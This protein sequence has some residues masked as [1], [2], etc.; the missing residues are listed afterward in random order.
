MHRCCDRTGREQRSQKARSHKVL[1]DLIWINAV[2]HIFF[3]LSGKALCHTRKPGKRLGLISVSSPGVH[4]GDKQAQKGFNSLHSVPT[5]SPSWARSG[6]SS[7]LWVIPQHGPLVITSGTRYRSLTWIFGEIQKHSH[8]FKGVLQPHIPF[9]ITSSPGD[10]SAV[11]ALQRP[12]NPVTQQ[13]P[14]QNKDKSEK[15]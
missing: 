14:G 4:P 6:A 15:Q 2:K 5:G 13:K 1:F 3:C 10:I 8:W 9:P 11:N 7:K 12:Y